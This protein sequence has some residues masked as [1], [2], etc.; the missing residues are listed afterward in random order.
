MAAAAQV[1]DFDAA[2]HHQMACLFRIICCC[3]RN[4]NLLADSHNPGT[5]I[6]DCINA[7]FIVFMMLLQGYQEPKLQSTT[8]PTNNHGLYVPLFG[9]C[10]LI[11][12]PVAYSMSDDE[13]A[14]QFESKTFKLGSRSNLHLLAND[15]MQ[16]LSPIS[17][18]SFERDMS[19][20]RCFQYNFLQEAMARPQFQA[21]SYFLSHE[22]YRQTPEITFSD[23]TWNPCIV[24]VHI[25][26][27]TLQ[28]H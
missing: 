9:V 20:P 28:N 12:Q 26:I 15:T 16:S 3:C 23:Q 21:L 17:S 18:F 2:T 14:F 7:R 24:C 27:V 4:R 19:A 8:L 11:L 10:G 25:P 22:F 6:C 13:D 5:E 1:A